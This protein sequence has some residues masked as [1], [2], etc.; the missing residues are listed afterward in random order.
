MPLA[1]TDGPGFVRMYGR[2]GDSQAY[3]SAATSPDAVRSYGLS[4]CLRTLDSAVVKIDAEGSEYGIIRGASNVCMKKV[5]YLA[6]EYHKTGPSEFGEMVAKLS[7]THNIHLFGSYE[8]GG[9]LYARI[10]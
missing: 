10:Y 4:E 8:T 6:M 2:Y 5:S 1:V 9:Y 3:T 7:R